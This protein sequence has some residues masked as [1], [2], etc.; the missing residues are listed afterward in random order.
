MD[1]TKRSLYPADVVLS[2]LNAIENGDVLAELQAE[3]APLI[4]RFPW[5]ADHDGKI[6]DGT[7]QPRPCP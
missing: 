3:I 1:I 4:G 6:S 7:K 2:T 5:A